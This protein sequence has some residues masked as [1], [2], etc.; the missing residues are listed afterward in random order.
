MYHVPAEANKQSVRAR[1]AV[2]GIRRGLT[3]HKFERHC[4]ALLVVGHFVWVTLIGVLWLQGYAVQWRDTVK[5]SSKVGLKSSLGTGTSS[6]RTTAHRL[7]RTACPA[8]P[9]AV[10][11]TVSVP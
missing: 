1:K 7:S 11:G 2:A 8:K 4:H 9:C 5:D 10:R 6:S 3:S